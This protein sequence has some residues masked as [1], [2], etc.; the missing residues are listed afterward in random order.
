[1]AVNELSYWYYTSIL[2]IPKLHGFEIYIS[3]GAYKRIIIRKFC[4][5][6][7]H[8]KFKKITVNIEF[9]D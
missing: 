3:S 2:I 5:Y 4:L 6:K 7:N 8:D 1:M 9:Y